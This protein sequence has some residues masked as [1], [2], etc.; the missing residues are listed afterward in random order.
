MG[1]HEFQGKKIIVFGASSGIGRQTAIQL[2]QMG[3]RLILVGRNEER[4]RET[5]EKLNG[6]NHHILPC[7]VSDFD[8]AH[9]V[10]K[11]SV[12]IDKVKLDGCVFSAGIG[13]KLTPVSIM[14][15][16][17]LQEMFQTNFFSFA[18]VLK[19]F[20]SRRISN[21]GASVVTLSSRDGILPGRGQAHYAA[22]KAAMNAYTVSAAKELAP[23]GIR[24]NA[25]CPELVDTPMVVSLKASIPLEQMQKN[26]PLGLLTAEDVANT[27]IYLLGPHSKKI[28]GQSI[29]L[30]AGNDGGPIEGQYFKI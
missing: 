23:R 29:W 27:I 6:S 28:T 12:N 30:S 7:D 9:N 16:Q 1:E 22:A 3:A 2:G 17:A 26:Y 11:D 19:A 25:I 8:A 13:A 24:V 20:S 4:L 15:L 10:V 21:D 18:A 14:K 5:A